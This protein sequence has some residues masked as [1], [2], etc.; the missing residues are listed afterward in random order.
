M[1]SLFRSILISLVIV[2]NQLYLFDLFYWK[3]SLFGIVLFL[4]IMDIWKTP[5][6]GSMFFSLFLTYEFFKVEIVGFWTLVVIIIFVSSELVQKN[7]N[8]SL[9]SYIQFHLYLV[10][11]YLLSWGFKTD[12][13]INLAVLNAWFFILQAKNYA[14]P[15][16]NR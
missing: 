11:Y 6:K 5:D 10:I 13:L 9:V 4:I 15:K 14:Y 3:I 2:F 16:S 12:F 8:Q 7:L 1:I